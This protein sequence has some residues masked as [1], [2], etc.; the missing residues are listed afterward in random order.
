MRRAW[1]AVVLVLLAACAQVP[2]S[3]P[4]VE[5]DQQVTDTGTTSFVRVL[6]RPPQPGMTPSDIVQGFLDAA[7]GFEDEHAVAREYLTPDAARQ[8]NPSLGVRVY[9]NDTEV[10]TQASETSVVMTASQLGLISDRSQ[11]VQSPPGSTMEVAFDLALVGSEWRIDRAPP[12]LL[13]SRAAVER[14]YREFETYYVARPGGIL[15]PNPVLF[16]SSQGDVTFDLVS[17]LVAGPSRWLAPAVINAFPSG[18]EVRG[19]RITDGV[20]VVDFNQAVLAAD[21]VARQ[22]LSAQLVWTLRQIGAISGLLITADGQPVDVPGAQS[23][24]P[25]TAWP[26]YDP[27][28]LSGNA[29]YYFSRAGKVVALDSAGAAVPVPGAAGEGDPPVTDPLVSLDQTALAATD[30]SGRLLTSQ[31]ETDSQ[32]RS[33]PLAGTRGGSWDR[34]GLLW[35]AVDGAVQAVNILGVRAVECPLSAITSVQISRDGSRAVVISDGR[36]YLLRVDRTTATPSLAGPRLLTD[37]G[38]RAVAWASATTVAMLTR[39]VDQPAQVATVDLGLFTVR[40]LGG[41]P[42]ARTVA[43]APDKPLLSG[44]GE[45]QIWSFNGSTWVPAVQGRGPRYPG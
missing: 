3:G 4:I 44:T 7:S 41:P 27:D 26:D 2:T 42:R 18:S 12:G 29:T 9:G 35:V 14:S 13:L 5:V 16:Q 45:G 17:A 37:V 10:L 15:A 21:P 39:A 28:G 22:Q 8:W 38:V 43:A 19:V 6:A 40:Y 36:A 1:M 31:V 30:V 24:Q 32:W 25:R 20:A 11:Y 34:T 23:P 33:G